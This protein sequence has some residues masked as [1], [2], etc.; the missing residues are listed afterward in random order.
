MM[1]PQSMRWPSYALMMIAALFWGILVEM[2]AGYVC[3]E[4][5]RVM[6]RDRGRGGRA[7]REGSTEEFGRQKSAWEQERLVR[8]EQE[9][10]SRFGSDGRLE[11]RGLS[12]RVLCVGNGFRSFHLGFCARES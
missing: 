4:E 7:E 10:A 11:R 2:E 12:V 6:M 5:G 9:G 8:R 1:T 3:V